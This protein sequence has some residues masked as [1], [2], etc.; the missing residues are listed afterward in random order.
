MLNLEKILKILTKNN[1]EFVIVGGFAS[2][3]HGASYVTKDF[4]ICVSFS[5]DNAAKILSAINP[6]RPRDRIHPNKP[7]LDETPDSLMKYKDLYLSTDLGEI[8]MLGEILGLGK[9]EDLLDHT[10]EVEL[11][12]EKCK[13]LDIDALIVAKKAL[14]RPKD[15][16]VLLQLEAIKNK[17][18]E[19]GSP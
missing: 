17:L 14:G 6:Y 2:I 10:I 3:I 7:Q 13:V 19:Q 8:D 18:E 15:I 4:D 5:K 1:V 11:Y 12:G 16:Q 9:F